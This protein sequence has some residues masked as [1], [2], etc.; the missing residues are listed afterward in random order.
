MAMDVLILKR[1]V[2]AL[3]LLA[4]LAA[5]SR[6][7]DPPDNSNPFDPNSPDAGE[8]WNLTASVAGDSVV[9]TWRNILP[10]QTGFETGTDTA[11]TSYT[12]LHSVGDPDDV[13]TPASGLRYAEPSAGEPIRATHFDYDPE[14]VNHY[15][16]RAEG[17]VVVPSDVVAVDAPL[18]VRTASGTGL[19]R[20]LEVPFVVRSGVSTQVE[21]SFDGS[22]T[23]PL[24]FDITPGVR[25]EIE[26]PIPPFEDAADTLRVDY[27]GRSSGGLGPIDGVTLRPRFEPQFGPVTGVVPSL[28]R[29]GSV[30]VDDTVTYVANGPGVLDVVVQVSDPADTTGTERI[31]V[32]EPDDPYVPF[33]LPLEFGFDEE[34]EQWTFDLLAES[35]LGFST[36]SVVQF[37]RAG[38]VGTPNVSVVDSAGVTTQREVLVT[39]VVTEAG[40]MLLSESPD[41]TGATWRAYADTVA[42]TLSEGL[43]EK[44]VYA[45]F[46]NDFHPGF[47]VGVTSTVLVD[48]LPPVPRPPRNR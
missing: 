30:A 3:A 18:V 16:V 47:R 23:D 20:S 42:F 32:A 13:D 40:E 19:A 4:G 10:D 41:F 7:V 46:R 24:S 5:C 38:P 36:V 25:T 27:R 8:G 31:T 29:R 35:E 21:F 17:V 11:L 12:L 34:A 2:V 44:T 9:V 22:F 45:G 14:R 37:L 1:A 15:R 43:G 48:S 26:L 28:E 39:S 33:R 6:D